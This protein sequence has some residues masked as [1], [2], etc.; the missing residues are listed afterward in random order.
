MHLG[1]VPSPDGGYRGQMA[2]LVKPNGFFGAAYMKAIAPFR[3]LIVY[4]AMIREIEREWPTRLDRAS[5]RRLVLYDGDCGFCMWLL[6][7][8]LRWDRRGPL[9]SIPLQGAEADRAPR[10]PRPGRAD[11]LLAPDLPRRDPDSRAGEAIPPLLR[12]LPGGSRSRPPPSPD[13]P[14]RTSR[15]YRWVAEHRSGLS[16]WVPKTRQTA[17]QPARP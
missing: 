11:G 17:C 16:R 6:A 8:L 10:R 13:S 14:G 7:G 9:R 12:L 2:V 1:W 5:Q 3:H 4:P 15:G